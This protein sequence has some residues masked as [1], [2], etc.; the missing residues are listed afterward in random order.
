MSAPPEPASVAATPV[1][2]DAQSPHPDD[3]G[4]PPPVVTL[5]SVVAHDSAGPRGAARGSLQ[6]VS[7]T[8][9]PGVH[10]FVGA[11]E[12][13]TI[14]LCEV[15]AGAARPLR[16]SLRFRDQEPWQSPAARA[17]V[18]ALLAQPDLPDARSVRVSVSLA[19]AAM[20]RPAGDTDLLL[21]QVGLGALAPRA[22]QTLTFAEAR[23]VELALAL[24][25]AERAPA[26][27]LLV[28]FEPCADVAI[29]AAARVV[30]EAIAAA[31]GRGACVVIAT[32][33]P[34][35]ARRLGDVLWILH[36]GA[37]VRRE[38]GDGKGLA[39]GD[40]EIVVWVGEGGGAA[41]RTL[42]AALADQP[43][44]RSTLWED[45]PAGSGRPPLLRVRGLDRDACALAV[46]DA[47]A[48]AHLPLEA[49]TSAA[50][51]LA[52][53]RS[54]SLAWMQKVRAA[55]RPAARVA[56]PGAARPPQKPAGQSEPEATPPP[57]VEA[58]APETASDHAEAHPVTPEMTVTPNPPEDR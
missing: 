4:E 9:G 52:A 29:P 49:I 33:S 56:V 7:L 36:R 3:A 18:G 13:G 14:A 16:G 2:A 28:L 11:P 46:I 41:V 21:A 22:T 15:L 35:D 8:L 45:P 48:R 5:D 30:D 26:P 38:A 20:A 31:R 58:V 55:V 40:A 10:V 6:G 51:D 53:V 1:Q 17:Q 19:L 43:A 47:A 12:D 34:A 57:Q 23:A 27:A 50:P 54:A 42:A 32:S 25:V 39:F 44:V 37:V 24:A